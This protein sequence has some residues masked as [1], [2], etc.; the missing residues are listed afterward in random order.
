MT[1]ASLDAFIARI[2]FRDWLFV[3]GQS[4]GGYYLQVHFTAPC[5]ITGEPALQKGGKFYISK[6][7]ATN[8]V[9]RTARAAI[10]SALL[11]E[12]DE[13]FL[14]DSFALYHPHIALSTLR[15]AAVE[16]HTYRKD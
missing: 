6:H 7:A 9:L 1:R 15:K 3:T 12:A 13:D 14:F 5:T 11:H 8:E 10:H 16:A 4:G 2:A